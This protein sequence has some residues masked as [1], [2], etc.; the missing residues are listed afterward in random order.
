MTRTAKSLAELGLTAQGGA[1]ARVTHIAIDSRKVGPGTLFAAL[2][3][4]QVH[5]AR[6]VETALAEGAVAR[7]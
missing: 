1:E 2:P 6:F 7:S 3:G 5:G 4:T